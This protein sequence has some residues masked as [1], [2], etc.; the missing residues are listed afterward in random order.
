MWT[1]KITSLGLLFSICFT[2]LATENKE[3]KR[4][5]TKTTWAYQTFRDT[6]IVNGHSVETNPEGELKMIISHRFGNVNGGTYELF[7]LDQSAIRF[8]FDYG[9]SDRF[10]VGFGRSS[11]QKTYDFYGKYKLAYQ[12]SGKRVMPFTIVWL[13]GTAINTTKWEDETLTNYFS[14]RVSYTHQ[15]II[16][17]KFSPVFSFQLMPTLVHRNIVDLSNESHDIIAL[18]AATRVQLT[19]VIALQVE[20]YYVLPTLLPDG[21]TNSLAIGFEFQTKAHVFQLHFSNSQGMIEN[22]YISETT[23]KW[24]DFAIRLGFNIT[25]DFKLKGRKY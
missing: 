6:R 11:F 4:D 15:L 17:R 16:G 12:K 8:G 23:G 13:S 9:I 1:K 2:L 22:Q 14:S 19:K 25:R 10:D 7:G 24:S 20:Y 3:A 18:G 5:T 21:Y